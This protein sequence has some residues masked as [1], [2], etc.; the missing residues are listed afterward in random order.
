MTDI[1]YDSRIEYTKDDTF[2]LTVFADNEID[3]G[4][5]LRFIIAKSE[6][7]EPII[8]ILYE[9]NNQAE[10]GIFFSEDEKKKI[11]IGDYLYKMI[12][13]GVDGSVITQLS[14]DF[15]VKWGA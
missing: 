8:D 9:M 3:A 15:I 10:F 12:L 11:L 6:T 13:I 7:Q 2:E 5:K 14:G 1:I 4:T